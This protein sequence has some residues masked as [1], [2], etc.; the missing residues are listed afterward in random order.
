MFDPGPIALGTWSFAGDT[1][2]GASDARESIAVIHAALDHGITL[3]DSAPNYGNGR[4]EEILGTALKGNS[5]AL[6]ATKRKIDG[7]SNSELRSGIEESA[8]RLGRDVID[9]IQIH[10]P[11]MQSQ[12]TADALDTLERLRDAGVVRAIGVCNFG[13]F[14]LQETRD[15]PIVSNQIPYSLMWR[16]VEEG[17][18][19][20]TRRRGLRT[21][22]YSVLQQGLLTGRYRTLGEF[23][24]G[25]KRT[26]HFA[27]TWPGVR[28]AE[29][30]MEE[31]TQS[32][33][34]ELLRISARTGRPLLELTLSYARSRPFIDTVLIGARTVEQLTRSCE[35]IATGISGEEIGALDAA[36]QRLKNVCGGNPDMYLT[37][38]RVRFPGSDGRPKRTV[39]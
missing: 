37:E 8:G 23:P 31:E 10:W 11:A 22:A 15:H 29:S 19:D 18:A 17:I 24:E 32:V 1:I 3:F 13:V 26:R 27:P 21:I 38:S 12:E 16:T 33:L 35:V 34:L 36:T 9:L 14:D 5:D 39:D 25:R 2:W 28:H 7:V 20:A 4:S 6:V 30:G